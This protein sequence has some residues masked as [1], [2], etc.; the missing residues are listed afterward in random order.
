[1]ND[2]AGQSALDPRVPVGAPSGANPAPASISSG[3][4]RRPGLG[5]LRLTP[6][7]VREG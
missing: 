6:H 1:M 5:M 3:R 4:P 2:D 7:T